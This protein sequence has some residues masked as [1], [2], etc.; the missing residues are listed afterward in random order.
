MSYVRR[1]VKLGALIILA[2]FQSY[3]QSPERPGADAALESGEIP[4]YT[5]E[6]FL[7]TTTVFGS[8]FAPAGD[9]ILVSSDQTGIY[10]AY[11]VPVDGSPPIQLTDSQEDAVRV[12]G[13]FP[14]DERFLYLSDQGGNELHHV[15][16]RELDGSVTDLTPGD[17]LKAVF[18]GWAHDDQSFFI[19]TNERDQRYFDV[20]EITADGYERTLIF[21][22]E[23]GLQF[24]AISPDER[25][26]ALQS[27][28]A[29]GE[30]E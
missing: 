17:G 28:G 4:Q 5:I 9:K 15:Y 7:A 12:A 6:Q 3:C 1:T 20:Y 19:G 10:N 14:A 8:S 27:F 23:E 25:Y 16:V 22:N 13:Y 26:L 2:V 29:G 11:A 24:G 18:L 21:R 30:G